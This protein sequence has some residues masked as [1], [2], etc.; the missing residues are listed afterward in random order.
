MQSK[1]IIPLML[2]AGGG[3][4]ACGS[5]SSSGSHPAH[6]G[7]G[8]P[9]HSYRV[10]LTG[11]GLK[12]AGAPQGSG[13]AVVALHHRAVVCFRFAHLHGFSGPTTAQIG[14]GAK[15]QPGKPVLTLS[16]SHTLRR[17]GCVRASRALAAA[18]PKSPSSYYLVINSKTYPEGAVRGQL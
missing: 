2:V 16:G 1:L 8:R 18:L 3:L 15:G 5:S 14:R 13:A 9:L 10:T 17:K 6:R 7:P 4:A 11:K 12:P